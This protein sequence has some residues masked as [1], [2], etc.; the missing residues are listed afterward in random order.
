MSLINFTG[1]VSLV[2]I[3]SLG[4]QINL[5]DFKKTFTAPKNLIIEMC[6]QIILLPAIAVYGVNQYIIF[7]LLYFMLFRNKVF[8]NSFEKI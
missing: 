1:S 3:F 2:I 6:F 4:T 7:A 8:K 5:D